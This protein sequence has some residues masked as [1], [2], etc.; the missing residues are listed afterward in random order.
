MRTEMD[1]RLDVQ[2]DTGFKAIRAVQMQAKH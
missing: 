1:A 2:F